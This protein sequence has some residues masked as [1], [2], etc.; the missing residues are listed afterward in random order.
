[1]GELKGVVQNM[2]DQESSTAFIQVAPG[3]R[4]A[5]RQFGARIG[6]FR[7]VYVGD[8]P[9]TQ[10]PSAW[11]AGPDGTLC[12]L[13]LGVA[14]VPTGSGAGAKP[15][16][17]TVPARPLTGLPEGIEALGA[18]EFQVERSLLR[19]LLGN[20][21]RLIHGSAILPTPGQGLL[22]RQLKSNNLL[23]K[24]GLRPGDIIT[25]INGFDLGDLSQA[26]SALARLQHSESLTIQIS[27]AGKARTVRI[28]LT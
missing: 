13:A 11:L 3:G 18:N 23:Y 26:M 14:A 15:T 17:N 2:Q 19:E 12:R 21:T 1:M 22:V 27:A 16:T 28:A 7:L 6:D 4:A 24:L 5:A 20:P 8:H 10:V 9:P 25:N